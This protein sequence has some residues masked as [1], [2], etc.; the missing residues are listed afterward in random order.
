M[1]RDEALLVL[2]RIMTHH[3]FAQVNELQVTCF[4]DE[5]KP[6]VTLP[7]A[8]AAVNE[9]YANP[10]E[11]GRWMMAG[12]VNRIV[13][14]HHR[15]GLPTEAEVTKL[16]ESNRIDDPDAAWQFRRTLFKA[17]RNGRTPQQAVAKALELSKKPMISADTRTAVKALPPNNSQRRTSSTEP[18]S[19]AAALHSPKELFTNNSK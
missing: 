18:A 1:S 11:N 4:C 12:D 16:L 5:I 10:P 14:R 15:A 6:Y 2:T 13:S 7:M 3:G 8:I 19:L 9:Y 17:L